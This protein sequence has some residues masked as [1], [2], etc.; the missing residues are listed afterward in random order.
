MRRAADVATEVIA[1]FTTNSA[2][3]PVRGVATK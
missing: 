1:K 2:K 3:I